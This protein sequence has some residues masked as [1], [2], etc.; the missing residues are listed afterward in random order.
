MSVVHKNADSLDL[1]GRMN[2]TYQI[3]VLIF[4][5]F[6]SFVKGRKKP[7]YLASMSSHFYGSG[8]ATDSV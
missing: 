3:G 5:I 6:R 1:L 4:S 8:I 7:L 2:V